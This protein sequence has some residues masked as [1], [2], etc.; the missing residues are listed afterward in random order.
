MDQNMDTFT[1]M[2]PLKSCFNKSS[3]ILLDNDLTN[4]AVDLLLKGARCG[5][6]YNTKYDFTVK[7]YGEDLNLKIHLGMQ[8][9]QSGN[10]APIL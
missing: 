7:F 4:E 10:F 2:I 9:K 8:F 3:L 6:V 1:F 5:E